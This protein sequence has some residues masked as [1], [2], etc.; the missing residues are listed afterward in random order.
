MRQAWVRS[1][2]SRKPE[3]PGLRPACSAGPVPC[4]VDEYTVQCQ[5]DLGEL[6]IIRLHKE[7][8]SF[9][10]K[11]PWYCNYVQ[12]CAPNGR[13][14][15]FPAYQWMDGYETLALREATGKLSPAQPMPMPRGP[16]L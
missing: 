6:I 16:L 5:Q 12:I 14:Y 11:N 4:Q 13:I 10:P 7:R 9:F 2:T 3:Q 8:Y 1:Q 15:H